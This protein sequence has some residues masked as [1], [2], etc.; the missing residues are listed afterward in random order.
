[1]LDML[2]KKAE[3]LAFSDQEKDCYTISIWLVDN[4]GSPCSG[5]GMLNYIRLL[6]VSMLVRLADCMASL[7]S[8]AGLL[9]L[10]LT[11]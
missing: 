11:V 7:C 2:V 10:A 9:Y 5:K 8:G 1:M 4:L 3:A 6:L